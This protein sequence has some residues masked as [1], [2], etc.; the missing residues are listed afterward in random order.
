MKHTGWAIGTTA[1]LTSEWLTITGSAVREPTLYATIG[2][3]LENYDRPRIWHDE[4]L[5]VARVQ[6]W[7]HSGCTNGTAYRILE[8]G[9][10]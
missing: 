7:Y 10:I 8:R 6:R 4:V 1:T 5:T 2:E 9:T 3:A